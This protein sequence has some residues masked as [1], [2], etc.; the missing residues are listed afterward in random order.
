[1]GER[2]IVLMVSVTLMLTVSFAGANLV[3][4]VANNGPQDPLSVVRQADEI[5]SG[6]AFPEAQRIDVRWQE[7]TTQTAC[8]GS[9]PDDPCIDNMI[10]AI[11]N[12]YSVGAVSN[13]IYVADP[14]TSLSNYDGWI[15]QG[16]VGATPIF[17]LAFR[18]DAV[19]INTPLISESMTQ[20]GI[21]E[22]GEI[23]QF[24]I[25]DYANSLG[26]PATDLNSL[27]VAAASTGWTPSTGSIIIAAVPEP[28]SMVLL[29]AG[30]MMLLRRRK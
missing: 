20:D 15:A 8:Q 23:W 1:M 27:G 2:C 16:P 5:G 26:G 9:P 19:G 7:A 12:N 30:G 6:K 29:A 10:V 13:L 25:Q 18:I 24:I 14:E 4:V 3:D 17:T 22:V 21:F 11:Q 28:I